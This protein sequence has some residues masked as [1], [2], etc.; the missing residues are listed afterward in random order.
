MQTSAKILAAMLVA[1]S[2]ACASAPTPPPPPP[3]AGHGYALLYEI[4]GQE[5][6]VSQLLVIKEDREALG[7]LIDA[8]A[9]TC[10]AAH[11]RLK[12]LA[13]RPPQLELVDTGLPKEELRTRE[14][15]GSQRKDLL[16][17]SSGAELE[18]Q[19][20]LIQN[21]ALTYMANLADTLSR[22][23]SDPER[24]AF[25]RALWK[26]MT[27]LIGDVQALLKRPVRTAR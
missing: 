12:E 25:V 8:I 24:L 19:L 17:G 5:A 6:K 15:I 21:E 18:F 16:L 7:K 10:G 2:L 3:A 4:L 9:E 11:E 23:E 27:R 26:D 22:S 20:L 14:L 1:S 13:E